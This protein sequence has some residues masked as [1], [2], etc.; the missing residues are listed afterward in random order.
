VIVVLAKT[1]NKLIRIREFHIDYVGHA[2]RC[3]AFS[4]WTERNT[5][6][7]PFVSAQSSKNSPFP[8]VPDLD[9]GYGRPP[10]FYRLVV[11]PY[12]PET[13]LN[14]L[15]EAGVSG[16]DLCGNGV[17]V[18]PGRLLVYRT[19]HSNRFRSEDRIK[20]VFRSGS[21]LV[22]RAFLLKPEY[23]SVQEAERFIRTRG[24]AITLPTISKVSKSLESILVI[25]RTR[26]KGGAARRLRLLQPDKLLDLLEANYVPPTVTRTIRGKTQFGVEALR[27]R[28]AFARAHAGRRGV[29]GPLFSSLLDL[30]RELDSSGIPLTIGGGFGLYLK[31][32]HLERTGERT[33]FSI[34]PAIRST[35][36]IDLFLRAEVLYDLSDA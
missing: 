14:D 36:D 12:L 2:H 23:E 26:G 4:V 3:E 10:E 15:E 34:L 8:R 24:G 13:R 17:V 18:V 27:E 33:L 6:D 32:L 29:M 16:I 20:N 30:L 21:S 22:A 35:K 7:G 11:A 28:L 9:R 1:S 31:R 5:V 19:G 25:D